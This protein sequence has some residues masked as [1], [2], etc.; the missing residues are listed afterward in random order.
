VTSPEHDETYNDW[1]DDTHLADVLTL[2]GYTAAARYR[3][4][5]VQAKGMEPAHRYLSIYEVE[6]D[7]LQGAIDTLLRA[8]RD[9]VISGHLDLANAAAHL[10]DEILPR[11][12]SDGR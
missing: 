9:M 10:Y 2:T 11:V 12:V 5:D 6:S 4:S 8:G 3:V 7:D 1:Y